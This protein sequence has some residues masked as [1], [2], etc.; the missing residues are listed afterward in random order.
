MADNNHNL[1]D[2]EIPQL[3]ETTYDPSKAVKRTLDDIIAPT[4][5]DTYTP[6]SQAKKSSLSDVAIPTLSDTYTPE[7]KS[8]QV[9]PQ[10][11]QYGASQQA[12]TAQPQFQQYGAPQQAAAAQPQF[13]QYGAPQQAAAAQPQFQQYGAPQQPA[14]AQPQFQQY[15]APQQKPVAQ[16][17][18]NN[19]SLNDVQAPLLED[20][21]PVQQ[22][23]VPKFVDPDIENAKK[24]AADRAIKSSLESVPDSFDQQKSREMYREFMRE[25]ESDM[26]KKGAKIVIFLAIAGIVSG[27]FSVLFALSPLK[28]DISGFISTLNTLY[29]VMSVAIILASILMLVNSKGTQKASSTMLTLITILQIIPG[30]FILFAKQSRGIASVFYIL[31]LILNIVI[32]FIFGSNENIK[33]HY[34][35]HEIDTY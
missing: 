35:G 9:Q 17:D 26:A 15:G 16:N 23:Y 3:E 12:A 31:S 27:A 8:Q 2:I 18:S 1:D 4:L 22:R 33:K 29:V 34:N 20:E 32:C 10:F 30:I 13:Q 14:S 11:Q 5:E 7:P 6:P 28:D 19:K 24:T 25:K 21:P